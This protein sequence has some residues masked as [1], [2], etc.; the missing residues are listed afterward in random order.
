[1]PQE[2]RVTATASHDKNTL[3]LTLLAEPEAEPSHAGKTKHPSPF[4]ISRLE[5]P[6]PAVHFLS[7]QL[8]PAGGSLQALPHLAEQWHRRTRG[9]RCV[10]TELKHPQSCS[11]PLATPHVPYSL[12]EGSSSVSLASILILI[13]V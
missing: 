8:T 4:W 12:A 3:L 5:C 13:R 7:A 6:R 1:M 2:S 11:T 9:T 10:I